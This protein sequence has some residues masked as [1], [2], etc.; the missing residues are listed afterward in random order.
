[1][2]PSKDRIYVCYI[3]QYLHNLTFPAH[4]TRLQ[5]FLIW[6]TTPQRSVI[7]LT[8]DHSASHWMCLW[9]CFLE[10]KSYSIR[11]IESILPD[12]SMNLWY[13]WTGM[14]E[15]GSSSRNLFRA[16]AIVQKSYPNKSAPITSAKK[17]ISNYRSGTLIHCNLTV[18]WWQLWRVPS[19][20]Y[21]VSHPTKHKLQGTSYVIA[22]ELFELS[23]TDGYQKLTGAKWFIAVFTTA[24]SS[25]V[26]QEIPWIYRSH[27]FITTFTTPCHLSL[28][29]AR[30]TLPNLPSS[31]LRSILILSSY[32]H[33]GLPNGLFPSG[34]STKPYMYSSS[35][36]Y[37][38]HTLYIFMSLV[39]SPT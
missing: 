14:T 26:S 13:H 6:F 36:S 28:S 17:Q 5:T 11:H 35:L 38:L 18:L 7:Y 23:N 29:S 9:N 8:K 4:Y 12:T 16:V 15:S 37:I 34:F 19:P 21:M 20:Y 3:L 31:C 10:S 27:R 24:C 39:W 32:P 1:M 2:K 30:S 22:N 33:L 25:S